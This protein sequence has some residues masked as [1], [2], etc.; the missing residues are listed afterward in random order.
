MIYYFK[1]KKKKKTGLSN[2][3]V[4]GSVTVIIKCFTYISNP[5]AKGKGVKLCQKITI[6]WRCPYYKEA[7]PMICRV[8]QWTCLYDRDFRHER[9]QDILNFWICSQKRTVPILE[10]N[11]CRT[12]CKD[13]ADYFKSTILNLSSNVPEYSICENVGEQFRQGQKNLY[14]EKKLFLQKT[15]PIYTEYS[16]VLW[17]NECFIINLFNYVTIMLNYFE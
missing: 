3:W 4:F 8:N 13:F 5:F 12:L 2:F 7:S 15:R 1:K 17:A 11:E 9:S 6:S 16:I 10:K 14:Q